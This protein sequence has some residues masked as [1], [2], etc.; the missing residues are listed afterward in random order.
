MKIR[1]CEPAD[2]PAIEDLFQEF[3]SYLRSIGDQADYRFSA[4][5]YVADG[6]GRVPSFR[7]LVAEEEGS[8]A[9]YV[10]FAPMFDGDYVRG[11]YIVDLYVRPQ[12]RSRGT[13]RD[14][15]K[16]V[17]DIAR[18]EG[19]KRL[20]WG[21]HRHNTRAIRFYESLGAAIVTESHTMYLDLCN[22]SG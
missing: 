2:A 17:E 19:R 20:T 8:I 11:L 21:V 7:G 9:G 6:F 3:V 13:G 4:E 10:L 15:M 1:P 22:L 16:A 14:L 18:A 5:Q 12:F